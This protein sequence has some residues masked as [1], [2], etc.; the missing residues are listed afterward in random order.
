MREPAKKQMTL[1]PT[2]VRSHENNRYGSMPLLVSVISIILV[3]AVWTAWNSYTSYKSAMTSEYRI[4]EVRARQ[5]EAR[6]SGSL[7]SVDLMLGSIIGDLKDKPT[8]TVDEQCQLFRNYLKQL[9]EIRSLLIT[10]PGGR[11]KAH[12]NEKV[13]GFNAADR[14]Y[15]KVHSNKPQSTNFH[16]STP[17]KTVTGIT[18]TTLSRVVLD[19]HGRFAGVIAATLESTFFDE[20]LKLKVFE[21]G[22][23]SLLINLNGDILNWVPNSDQNG[24]NIKGGIAYTEHIQSDKPT[25]RHLNRDKLKQVKRLSVFHNVPNSP[26]AVIVA[27]DYD[28]VMAEWHHAVY[29]HLAGFLVLTATT[30]FFSWLAARRQKSLVVAQ[31]EIAER[32]AELRAIIE[33]E[34]ECV[35]KLA[36][37]GTLLHMNRAGLNM[38]EADSLELVLGQK[39]QQLIVPEYREAFVSLTRNVFLGE[40]G[41]LE[42]QVQGLKGGY[43]W[44]ETHAVPFKNT[45]N[46]ITALLGITRDITERKKA[47]FERE[48]AL[49]RVKKLEGIIPICMHCKKIRDDQ[50][51][52]NQLEQYITNHSEAIFSH[53]ICP[54]CYDEQMDQIKNK[55]H[56]D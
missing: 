15:F 3:V 13:I 48:A 8:L 50:N 49:D 51:S 37:D 20:A 6:I 10:D 17:F 25:T 54:S 42:F 47:E 38:I 30:L 11:I 1:K 33:T 26:L 19:N 21:P 39:V 5:R 29:S 18:A 45:R 46:E 35:K 4:L 31:Q 55:K 53:G 28:S 27:R 34:P 2:E 40:S 32:E 14:E 36:L 12:T 52:W 44:L 9:P 22:V 43:R 56:S 16:I 7:R 23:E 41:T 24:K